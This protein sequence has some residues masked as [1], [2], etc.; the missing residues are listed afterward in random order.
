MTRRTVHVLVLV[1]AAVTSCAAWAGQR[2]ARIW[3]LPFEQLDADSSLEY[4]KEALPALLAVAISGS[5]QYAV[6]DRD[7]LK[8]LL[9]EQSLTI[10]GL[11]SPDTRHRIGRLLGATVMITGS[12]VRRDGDVR[13]TMRASDLET[14]IITSTGEARGPIGRA[15]ELVGQVY[16]QL[17]GELDKRLPD[18]APD[19]IDHAPLSNLHVMKGLGHYYS[20]RYSQ[21]LAEFMAAAD[22][23]NLNDVSR[24]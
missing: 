18:L 3:I 21:A 6:V 23:E 1:V 20:A 16:R 9:T 11:I 19:Q 7:N 22:D 12:F 13:I 24:L 17:A 10:E 2:P 8:A 14:G 5:D 4:L 15:G